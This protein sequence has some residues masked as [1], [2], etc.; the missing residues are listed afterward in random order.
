MVVDD[1]IVVLL[2]NQNSVQHLEKNVTGATRKIISQ[3]FAEAANPLVV[4]AKLN[5]ICIM[6][7]MRW[8]K[9]KSS[10]SI[11]MMLLRSREQ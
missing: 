2:T 10:S 9:R 8:R 7:F 6:M 11:T 1:I 3:S 4:E 5:V